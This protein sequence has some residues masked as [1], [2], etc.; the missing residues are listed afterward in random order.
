MHENSAETVLENKSEGITTAQELGACLQTAR[1]AC[2]LSLE[3]VTERT[4]IRRA[5]LQAFETGN[6]EP[7]PAPAYAVGFL[8]QYADLLGLD[9]EQTVKDYRRISQFGCE[10]CSGQPLSKGGGVEIAS[11]KRQRSRLWLW[12]IMAVAAVSA[13]AVVFHMAKTSRSASPL[14][15]ATSVEAVRP[16]ADAAPV[17]SQA[18]P[19]ESRIEAAETKVAP[20]ESQAEQVAETP[21]SSRLS[22]DLSN[23]NEPVHDAGEQG[24]VFRFPVSEGGSVFRLASQGGGWVELEADGR[25]LQNYDM[26]PGASVEWTIGAFAEIRF[27]IPGGVQAWLDGGE[28]SLP[29]AC[30]LFLGKPGPEGDATSAGN[31]TGEP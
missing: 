12:I 14:D 7:L 5:C 29:D 24:Q 6:Y 20:A 10:S 15:T 28:L 30:T 18:S 9:A 27:D 4:R 25:P 2:G 11:G 17:E 22:G 16:S 13:G 1:E 8:R 23:A 3:A 26:Q 31:G 21:D 19:V